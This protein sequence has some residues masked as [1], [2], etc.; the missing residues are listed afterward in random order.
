MSSDKTLF[1]QTKL[2][3]SIIQFAKVSVGDS[4][5]PTEPTTNERTNN[6]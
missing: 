2:T 5:K 1:M 4:K 3:Y 6:E